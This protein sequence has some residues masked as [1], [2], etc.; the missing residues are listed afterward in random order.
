MK[1]KVD[2]VSRWMVLLLAVAFCNFAVAQTITGTVTDAESGEPLIGANILVVG[3]ATGTVTDF[4]GTYSINVPA[5]AKQLEFSYTGFAAQTIDINGRT[6]INVEMSSGELLD[7]V[8]VIGYGTVKKSDLTGSVASL[9]ADDFNQGVVVA[10]DQLIQGKI[11]GV[12]VINNSGAPGGATTVRI[13]GSAS[14]RA[15]NEPLY[16]VDGIPLDGR[17]AL[18]SGILIDGAS[19]EG[20]NP[21]AFINPS[22]IESIQVLKDASAT[23]IYGSRGANGVII[24]T[25][26]KGRAGEPTLGFSASVATSSVLKEYETLDAAGY[27]DALNQYGLTGGDF[28]GSENAFDAITRNAFTQ[29]YNL[30]VGGGDKKGSYRVSLGYQDIQGVIQQSNLERYTANISGKYNLLNNERLNLDFNLIFARNNYEIT[31]ITTNPGFTGNLVA[32]ALQWNPTRPLVLPDGSYDIELGS[33][34]IN[35]AAM[36]DAYIDEAVVNTTIISIAPSYKITDNLTYKFQYSVNSGVGERRAQTKSW[37]NVQGIEG[38][39]IAAINN[40]TLTGQQFTHTLNWDYDLSSDISLNLLGGY[41]YLKYE[42]AES[43]LL[44]QDFLED[45]IDYTDIIQSASPGSRNIGSFTDPVNELQSY[46]GRANLSFYDKYL[47]TAT[48][49]ADGSSKFGKNNRY[50]VFPSIGLAWNLAKEDFISSGGTFNDLKLRASWGITGNQEFPAGASQAQ[51]RFRNGGGLQ[52][53]FAE[54]PDLK[55]ETST[56]IN[57]GLDF[58]ILDYR[59]SGSIDYFQK[60]TE[61]L[62]FN[63]PVVAPAPP[64]NTTQWK[65]IAGEVVNSGIELGLSTFLVDNEKITWDLTVNAAFLK[66]ELQNYEG[67][68]ITTGG[69]FGQGISGSRVQ[70]LDN[71]QPLNAFYTREFI[72]LGDDGVAIYANDEAFAYVGDPNPDILLGL[73][74]TLSAGNL[75]LGLNFNGAFGHQIYNNTANTVLPIGNLGSRNIDANLVGKDPQES[76]ANPIKSSSRYIEDGDYLKLANATVTYNLG[77]LGNGVRNVKIGLTGQNVFVLTNYTGFDPEVN[78]LNV[79]DGVPSFG[80]E[81]IPYPSARTILLS[82]SATF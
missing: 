23:A 26:R 6:A 61:D 20:V 1:L 82:L 58:A 57:V 80:I 78:T 74:T 29:N 54:N 8:V 14:I 60:T 52:R 79:T 15:G 77:D 67:A 47:L 42:N 24:V 56:M 12:Q 50:G 40:R 31:P 9:K 69:L 28:G 75:S 36:N 30:S 71:G 37:I 17:S 70:R 55:W 45:G 2:K 49:R 38:R 18:P 11:P 19:T 21:L 76:Q 35:P 3:T 16:V 5:D 41:E 7:E 73:S 53:A 72:E 66:N 43:G 48:V 59:V 13:R 39:G 33:T 62:L 68:P 22:D 27:R 34:T 4:D 10:P 65:N 44:G 51:Y 81:Y 64:D 63:S 32:Q 25:T 46:F